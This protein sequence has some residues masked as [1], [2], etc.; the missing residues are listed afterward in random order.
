[1][2]LAAGSGTEVDTCEKHLDVEFME[3]S[4]L[5]DV[6]DETIGGVKMTLRSFTCSCAC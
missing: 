3:L 2:G 6:G 1:M 4:D 5:M